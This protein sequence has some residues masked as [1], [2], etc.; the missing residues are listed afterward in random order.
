[1]PTLQSSQLELSGPVAA[2]SGIL[3]FFPSALVSLHWVAAGF[4][5]WITAA[6]SVW[7][8]VLLNAIASISL[9]DAIAKLAY[10]SG[11]ESGNKYTW[12]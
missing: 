1:M 9:I 2:C 11:G 10:V 6:C 5:H 7:A 8:A 3:L 12:S 4:L